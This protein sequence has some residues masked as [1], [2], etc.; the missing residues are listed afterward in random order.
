LRGRPVEA[1]LLATLVYLVTL[2]AVRIFTTLAQ[3]GSG[4]DIVIGATHVHHVVF[5]ILALLLAGMLSLDEL[6][7][8]PRAALFG[9]GAAL[10]LDEFA[11][12]VFLKDV[13]WLPQGSLSVVALVVGLVAL[14]INVWRSSDFIADIRGSQAAKGGR[15]NQG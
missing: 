14:V 3:T 2:L 5:G 15:S 13:Y 9:F 11:L 10:V 7:R 1:S 12:V 6:F 4:D 8:L